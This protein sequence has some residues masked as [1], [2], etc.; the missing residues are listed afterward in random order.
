[1]CGIAG[2][3][4]AARP[5]HQLALLAAR[6][7]AAQRHRG[8]DAHGIMR[9]ED[10]KTTLG[11]ARLK[12]LDLTEAGAQPMQTT[13]STVCISFNG[14]VYNFRELRAE[15]EKIGYRFRGRSD[16]EVV[17]CA[18]HHWGTASFARLNGM[19]AF[20]IA[21]ARSRK[22]LLVRDRLGIKPLHYARLQDGLIFAS[23]IKALVA[24]GLVQ[25]RLRMSALPEYLYFGNTLGSHTLYAD[26]ERLPPGSFL[27][28]DPW[29]SD[30]KVET[31]WTSSSVSAQHESFADAAEHVRVLLDKAVERQLVA[32]VPVG[33]FLSGGVDSSAIVA[34]AARHYGERLR[35]YSVGFDYV[36]ARNELPTARKT[37]ARFGTDHQELRVGAT[38]LIAVI[39]TVSAAHDAPFAD[40]AD[41]PLYQLCRALKGDVRVVLQGDGGDELFAGYRRYEY[42]DER[43]IIPFLM[44]RL[45]H[46]LL[47]LLSRMGARYQGARRF[48]RALTN[49][50]RA[51]A[52]AL[53]LTVEEAE[54][55]PL[56]V[57]SREVS[58]G[59]AG[60]DPFARYADIYSRLTAS[61]EVDAMLKTDVQILLPDIFLQKVDRSTMATSTEVRVPFLDNDLVEYVIGLPSAYKATFGE[62]KKVLR[63]ALRGIVPDEILDGKKIG[64]GV[65]VSA[66][67]RG[68]LLGYLRERLN[69][70]SVVRAGLLNRV[71]IDRTLLEHVAMRRD[72]GQILWKSL[73][74]ALWC[75]RLES[76]RR[77]A[78]RI[79]V[80][81]DLA[82]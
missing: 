66:W 41:I 79:D 65:P 2:I 26:V 74:L 44:R 1:M 80:N 7:N 31:Y 21:D 28:F 16:T 32:D 14:E 56:R 48:L 10:C 73:Q 70:E 24:S 55:S 39:E 47:P 11:H 64:F 6:M 20:A 58:I 61:D 77:H 29:S 72:N 43:A 23:E 3:V 34:M 45:G 69:D 60:I 54:Y 82:C 75:E 30:T 51:R 59:L 36:S 17:L 13:D 49:A 71:E 5:A 46:L 9:I 4:S 19:F 50:D 25:P 76:E 35:T 42:L 12:I 27:I 68:P 15:L 67:L 57:L 38:D 18:Y 37:A 63:A 81:R 8:P 33:V 40:A 52:M 62:R 53:L 22:V 78:S